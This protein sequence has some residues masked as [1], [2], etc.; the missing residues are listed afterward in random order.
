M[1]LLDAVVGIP[2]HGAQDSM[3]E[4]SSRV[5]ASKINERAKLSMQEPRL[6]GTRELAGRHAGA[7]RRFSTARQLHVPSTG[8]RG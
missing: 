3:T 7:A 6:G 8:T 5:F 2:E 1:R 4:P